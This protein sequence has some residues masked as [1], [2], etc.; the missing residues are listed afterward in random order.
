MQQVSAKIF[1]GAFEGMMRCSSHNTEFTTVGDYILA[2]V[3]YTFLSEHTQNT[4]ACI[5]QYKVYTY[6]G[7]YALMLPNV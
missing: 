1:T 6:M 3:Y 7:N 4:H 5:R 2:Q